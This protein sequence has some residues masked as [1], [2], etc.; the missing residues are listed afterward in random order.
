M[1]EAPADLKVNLVKPRDVFLMLFSKTND[2][3]KLVAQ[4]MAGSVAEQPE[5][6]AKPES[7]AKP[8]KQKK[9]KPLLTLMAAMFNAEELAK[10]M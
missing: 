8:E 1:G 7:V 10:F 2:R 4:K 6:V 3:E 9:S 5:E